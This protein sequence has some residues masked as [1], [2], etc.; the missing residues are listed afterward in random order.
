MRHGNAQRQLSRDG[1]HR[2]A[3]LRNMATSLITHGHI[4]TTLPKAKELKPVVEKLITLG[5]KGTHH[6]RQ[7][8]QSFL[9][10][11]DRK[12]DSSVR[13]TT[14]AHKLFTEIAERFK[15]RN[16]G[17]T[18]II[19]TR[20]RPGDNAQMAIIQMVEAEVAKKEAT[21]KRRVVKK[22]AEVAPVIEAQS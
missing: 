7:L 1:A 10:L 4:E 17:Y 5:K 19:R 6:A 15:D 2:R 8:A 21:K 14:A 9:M 22:N 11:N 16:G 3:L 18:R 20:R 12:A 13:K